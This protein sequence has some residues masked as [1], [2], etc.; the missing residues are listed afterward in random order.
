MNTR[1][2]TKDNQAIIHITEKIGKKKYV[3][4]YT[5][6]RIQEGEVVKISGINREWGRRGG[7]GDENISIYIYLYT[8]THFAG[9]LCKALFINKIK[10][11]I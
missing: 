5:H 11:H 2:K 1:C 10:C 8:H 7:I 4:I 9:I 6:G 3:K